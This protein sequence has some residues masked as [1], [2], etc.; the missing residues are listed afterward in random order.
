M[1]YRREIDG[2]RAV[3][4]I[5]V[6]LFHVGFDTFSGGFVGVDVFFVISGYLITSIILAEREA[7]T[8]SLVDFYERRVRRIVPALFFVMLTCIPFAWFW[9]SPNDMK[10]F[11]ESLIAVPVAVSNF[12]FL[13]KKWLF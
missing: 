7:G 12:L 13:L 2:L 5:P 11:S 4:V 1:E 3:A 8:F 6:I 9:L 10:S